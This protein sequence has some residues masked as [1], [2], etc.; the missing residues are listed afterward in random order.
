MGVSA[1]AFRTTIAFDDVDID[2][3]QASVSAILGYQISDRVGL[4]ATAGVI[5]GGS[6]EHVSGISGDVGSGFVTSLSATYIPVYETES[7]PF[8]LGTFTLGVSRTTA[9]SDNGISEDWTAADARLGIMVGKTFAERFV[10]FVAARVF[11]GPVNWRLA[12][13]DVIGSDI[14]HYTVGAGASYRIP[15]KLSIFAEALPLGEQSLNVGASVP[16]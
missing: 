5:L 11:G 2:L 10:P 15:G 1:G 13:Q 6:V 14:H 16:F 7:R 12:G 8:L 9:E 4:V 3:E